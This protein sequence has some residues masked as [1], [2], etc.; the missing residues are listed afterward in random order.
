MD[1]WHHSFYYLL[2]CFCYCDIPLPLCLQHIC[3]SATQTCIHIYYVCT[4]HS[5]L[6]C[7]CFRRLKT[8]AGM[9]SACSFCFLLTVHHW[10]CFHW[11]QGGC[12]VPSGTADGAVDLGMVKRRRAGS[13]VSL[14]S[15]ENLMHFLWFSFQLKDVM[16]SDPMESWIKLH[17]TNP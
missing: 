2:T 15:W 10:L 11:L 7:R 1:F 4:K 3:P 12:S 5:A 13:P 9:C 8:K 6:L 16:L 14:F 17:W